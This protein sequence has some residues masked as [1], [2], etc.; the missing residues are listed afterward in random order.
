MTDDLADQ[1]NAVRES[2]INVRHVPEYRR[3]SA[4]VDSTQA[5]STATLRAFFK[6]AKG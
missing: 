3:W 4:L 2:R 1:R 6:G 5:S